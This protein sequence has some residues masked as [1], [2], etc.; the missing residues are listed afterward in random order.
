VNELERRLQAL[1]IAFPDGPDLAPVVVARLEG[2]RPFP[3]RRATALALA[4]L[5]VA[6]GAAF[7]VPQARTTI[8]HWFH[9]GGATVERVKTLPP[10]AERRA[11]ATL[12][13]PLSRA[14]AENVVGFRL[15]LPP[16]AH[17]TPRVYV[18]A[19]SLATV[20]VERRG[21]SVLLSE[22]SSFGART[23]DKLAPQSV[24]IER[25]SVN[26]RPGL[27]LEGGP[28]VLRYFDREEGLREHPLLIRGNVLLWVRGTLTLRLEGKLT[29]SEALEL[30]RSIH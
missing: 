26:G 15:A 11:A 6:I 16:F 4:V 10:A 17:G 18:L 5:A 22:F 20:V 14:A 13:R 9:I 25:V 7:A 1:P 21:K 27:W 12:G 23:L 19:D 8:L 3:W 24:Q 30:A 29:R 28:H 2:R